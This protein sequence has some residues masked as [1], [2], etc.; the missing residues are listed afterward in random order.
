MKWIK[1]D[2]GLKIEISG[3]NIYFEKIIYYCFNKQ[4]WYFLEKFL[5]KL[6]DI[7]Q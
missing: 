5:N 2:S 4:Y 7:N 3:I 6:S 1:Q